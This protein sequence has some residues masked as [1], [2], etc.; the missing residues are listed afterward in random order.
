MKAWDGNVVAIVPAGGSGKRMGNTIPKQYLELNHKPILIHTLEK[1]ED[2]PLIDEVILAVPSEQISNTTALLAQW[3]I[4]K[5]SQVIAG[6]AHRQAS[7]YNALQVIGQDAS[8]ILTHDS[9]RP[10][11][12]VKKIEECIRKAM[13][14]GAAILATPEKCTVKRAV[15]TIVTETLD[16]SDLWQIQTPQVFRA[17]WF[18]EAHEKAHHDGFT[19]TDDAVLVEDMDHPVF[20]VEGEEHNI[21]I[22]TPEDLWI[23][24]AILNHQ[25]GE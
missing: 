11:V 15:D 20:I 10:F 9:V 6:G 23:A 7:V 21:K 22:T 2:C 25:N 8:V 5:V 18:R 4:R 17:D 3:N 12:S 14:E 24:G 13:A 1:L 16:R 19:G